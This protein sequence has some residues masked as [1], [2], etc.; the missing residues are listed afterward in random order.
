MSKSDEILELAKGK[1]E[2]I[3][4]VGTTHDGKDYFDTS[5]G[6]EEHKFAIRKSERRLQYISR[7]VDH[8]LEKENG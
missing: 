4:I 6:G 8:L 7:V 5:H 3:T 1:L 2:S